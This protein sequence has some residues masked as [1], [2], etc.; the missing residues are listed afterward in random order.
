MELANKALSSYDRNLIKALDFTHCVITLYSHNQFV[1]EHKDDDKMCK[2]F[3]ILSLSFG[4][5]AEAQIGGKPLVI[6]DTQAILFD[7]RQSHRVHP[8]KG[9]WR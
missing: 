8:L 1:G 2:H 3:N 9:K 7:G 6:T 5:A 4:D